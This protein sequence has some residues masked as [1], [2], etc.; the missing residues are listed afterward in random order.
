MVDWSKESR[1]SYSKCVRKTKVIGKSIAGFIINNQLD[2][3]LTYCIGHSLGAH[4]GRF[5][6][7]KQINI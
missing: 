2:P 6:S 4:V 5:I 1:R 3:T 7:L